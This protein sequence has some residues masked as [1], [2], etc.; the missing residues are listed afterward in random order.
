M[1]VE[2]NK[3]ESITECMYIP[4][5]AFSED[6]LL[7]IHNELDSTNQVIVKPPTASEK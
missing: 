7:P 6:V 5:Q 3:K 2:Q 4:V 1:H